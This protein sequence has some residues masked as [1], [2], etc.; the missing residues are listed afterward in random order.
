[1][2]FSL[3]FFSDDGATAV[4]VALK[5]AF[6]YW[7]QKRDPEPDRTLFLALGWQSAPASTSPMSQTTQDTITRSNGS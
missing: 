1:M 3:F 6:Q 2:R 4:E 7:R 5:M